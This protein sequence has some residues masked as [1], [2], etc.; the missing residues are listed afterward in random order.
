M[1][2]VDIYYE[3]VNVDH[4]ESDRLPGEPISVE[5][6]VRESLQRESVSEGAEDGM[7]RENAQSTS[8]NSTGTKGKEANFK[9][10]FSR[11]KT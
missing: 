1:S 3:A 11:F 6:F 9:S 5:H 4:G 2:D 8:H 10:G 7:L